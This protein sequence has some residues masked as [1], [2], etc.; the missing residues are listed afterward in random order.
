L[1]PQARSS[2]I[3]AAGDQTR[4]QARPQQDRLIGGKPL[5]RLFRSLHQTATECLAAGVRKRTFIIENFLV[6]S[7]AT[8]ILKPISTRGRDRS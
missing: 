8:P 1:K 7:A 6:V 3:S 4:W 5:A 2:P